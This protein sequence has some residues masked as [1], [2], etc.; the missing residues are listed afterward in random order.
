[1]PFISKSKDVKDARGGGAR[2]ERRA[3]DPT[4]P[5]TRD[6]ATGAAYRPNR[7]ARVYAIR[8]LFRPETVSTDPI[9]YRFLNTRNPVRSF[10]LSAAGLPD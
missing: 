4:E 6:P 10:A 2:A 5:A 7:P 9:Q 8:D 1:M 3:V